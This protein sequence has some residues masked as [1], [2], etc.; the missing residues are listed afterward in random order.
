MKHFGE[1]TDGRRATPRCTHHCITSQST[2]AVRA[3][4]S[5]PSI[6]HQHSITRVNPV[7]RSAFA[8]LV[9]RTAQVFTG[10]PENIRDHVIAG[11]KSLMAGDWR[12]CVEMILNLDVWNL[13]P[14]AGEGARVKTMLKEKIQVS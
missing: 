8:V 13:I 11:A 1:R 10:P 12:K 5:L 3:P 2:S 14:G 4:P 7:P 6:E 9:R